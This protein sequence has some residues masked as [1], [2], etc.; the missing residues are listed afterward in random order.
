[1]PSISH[2]PRAVL[3]SLDIESLAAAVRLRGRSDPGMRFAQLG[4]VG[5]EDKQQARMIV[6]NM[7]LSN[8][9]RSFL[10]MP[11]LFFSFEWL[12]LQK[13]ERGQIFR[14]E[15]KRPSRTFICGIER[16]SEIYR[17]SLRFIP[18]VNHGYIKTIDCIPGAKCSLQTPFIFRYHQMTFE[19]YSKIGRPQDAAFLDFNGP[20]SIARCNAIAA[21]WRDS[22][23]I[24]LA[25]N[26]MTGRSPNRWTGDQAHEALLDAC[27]GAD[28]KSDFS[29]GAFR[30]VILQRVT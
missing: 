14:K 6:R 15:N 28:K 7:F 8:H 18:H 30:Q 11:G 27:P 25:V 19:D 26:S 23:P 17:G 1:M 3:S 9:L 29:Y 22:K 24:V 10:T 4:I 20:L 12:L 5:S 13:R 2:I 21:F 16:E